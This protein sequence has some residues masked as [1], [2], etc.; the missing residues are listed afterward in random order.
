MLGICASSESHHPD[1]VFASL[2]EE[3]AEKSNGRFQLLKNSGLTVFLW[4]QAEQNYG[5][6][7]DSLLEKIVERAILAE[8][9]RDNKHRNASVQ[10]IHRMYA[11]IEIAGVPYRIK[12]TVRDD[13]GPRGGDRTNLHALVAIEIEKRPDVGPRTTPLD[14]VESGKITLSSERLAISITDLLA[15]S[16][17]HDRSEWDFSDIG[18]VATDP[19]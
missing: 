6:R 3:L 16:T 1:S 17:R 7:S 19:A 2:L 4:K 10:G 9:H 18:V 5:Y 12:L 14:M 15:M 8:S 13:T 11:A